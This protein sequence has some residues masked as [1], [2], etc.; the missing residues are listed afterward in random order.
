VSAATV[1]A[2]ASIAW[3]KGRHANMDTCMCDG[4]CASGITHA[5]EG[6]R[7]INWEIVGKSDWEG[8]G[9]QMRCGHCLGKNMDI[10][11]EPA[12]EPEPEPESDPE[13]YP[14]PEPE[15]SNMVLITLRNETSTPCNIYVYVKKKSGISIH[16]GMF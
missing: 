9:N 14:E 13:P 7:S 1:A 5:P 11:L 3:V 2:A 8:S 10:S 15:H 12:L 16:L 6:C 4:S